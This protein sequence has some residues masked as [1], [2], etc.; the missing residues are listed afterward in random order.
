[1]CVEGG[2]ET[3]PFYFHVMRLAPHAG[4][5]Y[6]GLEGVGTGD[7]FVPEVLIAGRAIHAGMSIHPTLLAGSQAHNAGKFLIGTV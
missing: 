5:R 4:R 2:L 7:L 1:M 3:R 6:N